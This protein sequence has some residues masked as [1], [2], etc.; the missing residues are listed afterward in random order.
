MNRTK[1]SMPRASDAAA[2]GRV[3]RLRLLFAFVLVAFVLTFLAGCQSWSRTTRDASLPTSPERLRTTTD[4]VDVS[5]L[6]LP[7]ESS[8]DVEFL[9]RR[10]ED[11][12]PLPDVRLRNVSVTESGLYDAMNLIAASA[13]LSLSIEGG[14]R[15]LERYGATAVFRL[16]GTLTE[17]M[18]QMSEGMGFF[19]SVR[20]R[21]LI[22]SP[23][24]QFILQTPPALS[25][26]NLAGFANNLQVL[27]A[28]DTYLDRLNSSVAFRA[29][30]TA[31]RSIEQYV[32][33][34][35]A[36]RAMLIYEILVYQVD[37]TDETK[38]GIN[39]NRFGWTEDS[40]VRSGSG[41]GTG[42]GG[43]GGG[44]GGGGGAPPSG[45]VFSP[46]GAANR[47]ATLTS[48]SGY[49]LSAVIAGP[50]FNGAI[51]M[52]FLRSQGTVRVVSQ[53]R[54]GL[55]SG[56]RSS[57]QVG[58]NTSY[59][60]KV[61]TN[62]GNNLNQVT[63]ETE[64]LTT[65]FELTLYGSEN[66]GA[67]YTDINL[68]VSELLRFN[69]F[70]A[71]GTDLTLPQTADRKIQTIVAAR[72]GDVILLGGISV[73]RDN[74]DITNAVGGN[75]KE[76]TANRGELVIAIRP[77]VVRFVKRPPGA[78][79]AAASRAT[80]APPP[81]PAPTAVLPVD[82]VDPVGGPQTAPEAV[83]PAA[84]GTGAP[85][86]MPPVI[87]A[88]VVAPPT[89]VAP[90]PS[91]TRVATAA[92]GAYRAQFGAYR[93][94]ADAARAAWSLLQATHPGLKDLTPDIVRESFG[95]QMLWLLRTAPMGRDD[96]Q[97][98]CSDVRRAGDP[99]AVVRIA[100]AA[101]EGGG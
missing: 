48:D 97:R 30:R 2:D 32:K 73:G 56:S 26:D 64:R 37:L 85:P 101:A 96:V 58:Q 75:N 10:T 11:S 45:D 41:S 67:I 57:L 60:A 77:K 100:P 22:I 63:V 71:L 90:P 29:N 95:G 43:T 84:V 72:P 83:T 88:P 1:N 12:D 24:Q 5:E 79:S 53:P 4:V 40:I 99:C 25:E 28:R 69:S 55:M 7:I 62:I 13:N 47:A 35:R 23:E 61:G 76:T 98:L 6:D 15:G 18:E 31:L 74:A 42:G 78:S 14:A 65:G 9:L 59:V 27:G 19:Y 66:G 20:N 21:M 92:P 94:G 39:W 33:Q 93:S 8:T 89:V 80:V 34:L 49:G 86:V 3:P 38:S 36:S 91:V 82:W 68:S 16:S 54:I 50:N 52:N 81:L 44:S 70:T 51:L 87:V 46:F 17:V